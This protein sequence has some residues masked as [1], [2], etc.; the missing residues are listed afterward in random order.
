MNQEQKQNISVYQEIYQKRIIT[1]GTSFNHTL[2]ILLITVAALV[3][4]FLGF[5]FYLLWR[6]DN[7]KCARYPLITGTIGLIL[8]LLL[9]GYYISDLL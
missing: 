8:N 5:L 9:Y 1:E 3:L 6:S 2:K 7:P 4:P